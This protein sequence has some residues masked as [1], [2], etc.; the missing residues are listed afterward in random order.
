MS[1]KSRLIQRLFPN[2]KIYTRRKSGD[3]CLYL[4]FDDGPTPQVTPRVLELLSQ[5]DTKATFFFIG[6]RME[7]NPELVKKVK[8]QGHSLG[9]HSYYHKGF[10]HMPTK[11][12]L[13]E[14]LQTNELLASFEVNQQ[15]IIFRPPHGRWRIGLLWQLLKRNIPLVLWSVDSKDYS[16]KNS[17]ILCRRLSEMSLRDGD[18][19]LFHDDNELCLE[20][21][22]NLIPLWKKQGFSF[23][24]L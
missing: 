15:S 14:I 9:N 6:K 18:I 22:D 19:I 12:Q 5:H 16:R 23:A 4:T 24:T 20:I 7:N 2:D 10:K 1:F 13:E 11:D 21:L 17:Q 3:K 8:E